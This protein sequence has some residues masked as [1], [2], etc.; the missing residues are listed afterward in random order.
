MI[1]LDSRVARAS[2]LSSLALRAASR[3]SPLD[4]APLVNPI[5]RFFPSSRRRGLARSPSRFGGA[6]RSTARRRSSSLANLESRRASSSSS[7][8]ARVDAR[9]TRARAPRAGVGVGVGVG[10]GGVGARAHRRHRQTA[11]RN[12][13][14]DRARADARARRAARSRDD[15]TVR[16]ARGATA[17]RDRWTREGAR[18]R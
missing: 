5:A 2:R 7:A 16:D 3:A 17:T 9:R 6:S 10:G 1:S 12:G 14:D 13:D 15:A 18:E 11:T 4:A 8:R